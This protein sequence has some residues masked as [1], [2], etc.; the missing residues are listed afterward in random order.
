M[1]HEMTTKLVP[2]DLP[3]GDESPL[4]R[5]PLT[6]VVAQIRHER[7]LD[8]ASPTKALSIRASLGEVEGELSEHRQQVM[9]VVA[10]PGVGT[11]ESS[12]GPS[13]WQLTSADGT[14]TTVIQQEFFS[15]ETTAYTTW[16]DFRARLAALIDGVAANLQPKIE[17]RVGLRYID[18]ISHSSV[19]TPADWSGLIDADLLG[20][21]GRGPLAGSVRASQ[22]IL[23]IEGSNGVRVNLRHG[24]QIAPTGPKPIY[25]LDLDCYV[26][27]GRG[28]EAATVLAALDDLHSIA[29]RLFQSCITP[30]LL[31]EL[32]GS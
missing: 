16:A 30:E 21:L 28:F 11:A 19:G 13:G 17:Q 5:S 15:I 24:S 4:E 18:T 26:Q 31:T 27:A 1:I 20:A 3:D 7:L 14:S 10:G 23:E 2:L 22:Q 29:L 6:L 25:L 12:E 9:M 8:A 32:S